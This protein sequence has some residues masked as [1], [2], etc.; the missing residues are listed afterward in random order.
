MATTSAA[1]RD[2]QGKENHVNTKKVDSARVL[3][4]GGKLVNLTSFYGLLCAS[5][6]LYYIYSNSFFRLKNCPRNSQCK[7]NHGQ[8][9]S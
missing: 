2:C 3:S 1:C 4:G 8:R 7:R 9:Q 5:Q 6:S